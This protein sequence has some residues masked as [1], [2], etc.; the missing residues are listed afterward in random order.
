MTNFLGNEVISFRNFS[1]S[2]SPFCVFPRWSKGA[3]KK[4]AVANCQ[5]L[6]V[7]W[8]LISVNPKCLARRCESCLTD[9]EFVEF[10]YII[11][12]TGIDRGHD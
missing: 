6:H 9:T 12:F 1:E 7:V 5:L 2:Y 3:D 4:L 10:C 11:R 8:K